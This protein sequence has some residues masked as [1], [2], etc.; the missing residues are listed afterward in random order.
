MSDSPGE[1]ELP[2]GHSARCEAVNGC[3]CEGRAGHNGDHRCKH[4]YWMND[5]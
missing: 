4:G 3:R 5:D 2:S 1:T